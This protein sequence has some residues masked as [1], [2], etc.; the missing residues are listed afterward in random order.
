MNRKFWLLALV[1][2]V[3][4]GSLAIFMPT[5]A[6]SGA[7]GQIVDSE[8]F[9]PWQYG[10]DVYIFSRRGIMHATCAVGA[11]DAVFSCVYGQN[12]LGHPS[13]CVAPPVNG[14]RMIV[15]VDFTCSLSGTCSG[16]PDGTPTGIRCNYF[17]ASGGGLMDC[18]QVETITGPT[19]IVLSDFSAAETS[20]LSSQVLPMVLVSI[21][22]GL[23]S[24]MV[25]RQL[26]RTKPMAP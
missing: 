2:A 17:E 13:C 8:T 11:G 10:G 7:T 16:G 4:L 20:S 25:S 22:L 5:S 3:L 23:F 18:Q 21:G 24:A 14:D 9:N 6:F 1:A 19:A 26:R 12:D 15:H